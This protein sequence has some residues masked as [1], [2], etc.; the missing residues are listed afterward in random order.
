MTAFC[1]S[2]S[3]PEWATYELI[4]SGPLCLAAIHL[5]PQMGCRSRVDKDP[6]SSET[7]TSRYYSEITSGCTRLSCTG[8]LSSER[9]GRSI[10][11]W[12]HVRTMTSTFASLE[13]P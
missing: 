4:Q 8:V 12:G 9:L 6:V 3:K 2:L 10:P 1:P 11:P 7:I 5:S 13:T